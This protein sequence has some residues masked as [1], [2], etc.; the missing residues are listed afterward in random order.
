MIES[1]SSG[2][3]L[4]INKGLDPIT[5]EYLR[6]DPLSLNVTLMKQITADVPDTMT[7]SLSCKPVGST[8]SVS[9]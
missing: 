8:S 1:G 5:D 6:F 7:L 2:M 4:L 3:N 9:F